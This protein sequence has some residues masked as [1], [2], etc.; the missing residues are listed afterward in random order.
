MR[1]EARV[2]V[3][4]GE[5]RYDI[6][7]GERLLERAGE[8]VSAAVTAT[9]LA[10]ISTARVFD[11][12]G[13][14]LRSS[15]RRAGFAVSV[16]LVGEGERY[17]TVRTVE[18][19]YG[20]LAEHHLDRASA[21][22]ALGG[23]VVG[24]I[25]GFVAATFLRGIAYVQ[26]PTT[27]LA[28]IDSSIGGKTGVNLPQGKNL[29]G[30]FHH[31]RLVLADVSTLRTLPRREVAAG[32]CEALKYGVI[33]DAALF[34]WIVAHMPML[35]NGEVAALVPMIQRCCEI[36]ADIVRRDERESGLR[37]ILNFGHTFGH[38]LEAV[39]SY[40]RLRHGEAVGY[41]MIMAARLAVRLGLLPEEE[42]ESIHRAV[43]AC[44]RFPSIA[45]LDPEDVLAA[46]RH[47]KKVRAGRLTFVVPERIGRVVVRDDVPVRVVR[48]VLRESLRTLS[49]SSRAG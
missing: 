6:L 39:T 25:A 28:A 49:L 11:L 31:P 38:A 40:R 14:E 37:R 42:A 13:A 3:S 19:L 5:R 16:H 46:M 21:I 34:D 22:L 20:E 36:K 33:R 32:L 15:L 43:A 10:I 26:V 2:R 17:K 48:A 9:R 44:G 23:G 24:D 27:L 41:G 45:D 8:L 35:R 4:L 1:K 29:V 7:I 12:Y 30:A 47:D 18:R